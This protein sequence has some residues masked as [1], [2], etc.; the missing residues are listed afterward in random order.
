MARWSQPTRPAFVTVTGHDLYTLSIALSF[1]PIVR[2]HVRVVRAFIGSLVN[3]DIL[4]KF[5]C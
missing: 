5:Q 2:H 4:S 1:L 3:G